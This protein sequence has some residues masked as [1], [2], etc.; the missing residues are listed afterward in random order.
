MRTENERAPTELSGEGLLTN[1]EERKEWQEHGAN[2]GWTLQKTGHEITATH[3]GHC[4]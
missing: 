4:S 2:A 3:A 1:E